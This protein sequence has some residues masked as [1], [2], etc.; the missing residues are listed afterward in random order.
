MKKLEAIELKNLNLLKH[1]RIIRKWAS[2]NNDLREADLELLIY[3]DCTDLFTKKDFELGVYSYSWDNRRWS[4]LIKGD[5]IKVW[6][7]RNRTTQKYNIYTVSFKGKQLIN[8][9]YRIMLKEED[10]PTSSRRNSI[11]KGNSYM[12]KVLT[13][14]IYNVNKDNN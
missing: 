2:K 11:I 12:D 6:R 14:A 8:R 10:L 1:Y 7:T 13:K 5:W 3:L 4:R 9:I